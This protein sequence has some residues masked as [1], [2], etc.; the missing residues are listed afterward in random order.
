MCS[1]TSRLPSGWT[2]TPTFAAG[3]ETISPAPGSSEE[4]EERGRG[5]RER[6][7]LRAGRVTRRRGLSAAGVGAAGA[8]SR[9][10]PAALRGR[11]RPRPRRTPASRSRT[12]REDHGGEGLDRVVVRQ[13]RVVVDLARDR[14]LVLRVAELGLQLEEVLVRLQVRVGLG[15]R[16][17]PA[18]RLA[19]DALGLRRRRRGPAPAGPPFGL[20]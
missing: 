13:H 18:E 7:A 5:D 11:R 15:D 16:E 19:Q 2:L 10:S 8:A 17:Q 20:R 9:S 6:G 3:S 12:S 1:S 4:C 14:D